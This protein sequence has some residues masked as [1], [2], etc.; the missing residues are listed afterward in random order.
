MVVWITDGVE[1]GS[2]GMVT[3]FCHHDQAKVKSDGP[4]QPNVV[5]ARIFAN[6]PYLPWGSSSFLYLDITTLSS[7][8][9]TVQFPLDQ[10][11]LQWLPLY[12]PTLVVLLH[13][14]EDKD[15]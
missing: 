6:S 11:C 14:A 13:E 5:V 4:S 10:L 2:L 15:L 12:S 1:E 9:L 7:A 3:A 8:V